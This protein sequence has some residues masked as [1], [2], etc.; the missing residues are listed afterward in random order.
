MRNEYIQCVEYV[1]I[2][3]KT[4]TVQ[5]LGDQFFVSLILYL[6]PNERLGYDSTYLSHYI[7]EY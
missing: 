1:C 2:L 7:T 6:L 5:E 3:R 4:F